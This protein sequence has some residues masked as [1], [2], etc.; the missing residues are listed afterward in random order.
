[1]FGLPILDIAIGL[2]FVYLL[3]A[4]VCTAVTEVFAGLLKRR[5]SN[6][7]MGVRNLL[8]EPNPAGQNLVDRLYAHPLIQA[9]HENGRKPSYIPSRTFALALLDIIAPADNRPKLART[10][11]VI[12]NG[13][14]NNPALQKALRI[15]AEDSEN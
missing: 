12:K 15:L 4:L 6:L 7:L 2:V 11:E 5:A 9:L 14:P 3:L 10:N 13:L 1:M 8:G